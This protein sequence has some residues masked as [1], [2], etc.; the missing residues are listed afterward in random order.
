VLKLSEDQGQRA[1][2]FILRYGAKVS[3]VLMGLGV[4]LL[5]VKGLEPSLTAQPG[6]RPGRFL[7]ELL[8]FDPAALT[9]GGIFLL[10]LTPVFAVVAAV[11]SFALEREYKYF[12]ISLG[13]LAVV[14]LSIGFA[15]G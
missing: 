10:L 7:Q 11:V 2:A 12:L 8:R 3:T 6:V 5:A 15:I 4:C 14:L 13:V 9:Q 1:I